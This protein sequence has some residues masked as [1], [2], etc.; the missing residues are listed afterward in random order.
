MAYP[1]LTQL[2]EQ[3]KKCLRLVGANLTTKEIARELHMSPH[4][5]N[6]HCEAAARILNVHGRLAAARLLAAAERDGGYERFV[7]EPQHLAASAPGNAPYA[8]DETLHGMG[9][10]FGAE[11]GND[12]LNAMSRALLDGGKRNDLTMLQRLGCALLVALAVIIAAAGM[13]AIGD[14]L[15]DVALRAA[16]RQI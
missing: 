2:N 13:L 3:Q 4:T 8:Q 5:V 10:N 6:K 9:P 12:P 1:D 11:F 15:T 14:K 16:S 7:Y